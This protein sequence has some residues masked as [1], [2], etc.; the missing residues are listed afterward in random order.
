M[1]GEDFDYLSM[2]GGLGD[3][4]GGSGGLGAFAGP[5]TGDVPSGANTWGAGDGGS[6]W[7]RT[8]SKGNLETLSKAAATLKP[9]ADPGAA[10]A[11]PA[12][13]GASWHP[14]DGGALL[15]QYVDQ[16]RQRQSA[17]RSQFMPRVS[18]L[19]GG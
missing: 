18:G 5:L 3:L 11:R 14:G 6:W 10:N 16:L 8:F 19:L 17:L 4:T 1:A 7:D 13:P 9:M 12:A 2:L 15:T